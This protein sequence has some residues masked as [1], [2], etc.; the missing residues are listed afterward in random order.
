MKARILIAI[1]VT[2]FCMGCANIS[3]ID[4]TTTLPPTQRGF[5]TGTGIDFP[6]ANPKADALAI[7]LD[8]P[9]RLAFAKKDFVCVEPSPDALQAYAS[10]Q[11]LSL[12]VPSEAEIKFANALAASASSIGLRTQSIT[13]M[14]DHLYRICEAS[15]NNQ[16]TELDVAQLL[17]RSQ[18]MTLGVLA[19]EQLTGAVAASQVIMNASANANANANASANLAATKEELDKARERERSEEELLLKATKKWD[20]QNKLVSATVAALEEA[21]KG[22]DTAKINTLT[23][24][25]K[26]QESQLII[27]KKAVEDAKVKYQEAIKVTKAI[28]ANFDAASLTAVATAEGKGEFIESANNN[29][30]DKDTLKSVSLAVRNIVKE[31]IYKDHLQDSCISIMNKQVLLKDAAELAK[32]AMDAQKA[33]EKMDVEKLEEIPEDEN[34]LKPDENKAN[35]E[36]TLSAQLLNLQGSDPQQIAVEAERKLIENEP[37]YK[38]CVEALKRSKEK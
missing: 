30:V 22:T 29:K 19:I 16:I 23:N 25:K 26:E 33:Y 6:R 18:D 36:L 38:A 2:S 24:Q 15:Y 11:A 35:H 9:Q 20:E 1:A 17:R 14:R 13:L 3:T 37:L 34:Q 28:K 12:D 10:S 5:V 7:H 4:R 21:K 8:A 32:E 31:V 27:D